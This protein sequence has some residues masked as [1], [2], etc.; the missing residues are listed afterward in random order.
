[1]KEK[2][3]LLDNK[4]EVKESKSNNPN[5]PNYVIH[6]LARELMFTFAMSMLAR[7]DILKWKDLMEGKP[8]YHVHFSFLISLLTGTIIRN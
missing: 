2:H 7:Y 4:V 1:M 3:L 5:Y 8:K 6:E